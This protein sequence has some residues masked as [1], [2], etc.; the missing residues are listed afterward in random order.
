ML[1]EEDDD[2]NEDEDGGRPKQHTTRGEEKKGNCLGGVPRFF[3]TQSPRGIRGS[4]PIR[5]MERRKKTN[6]APS[7]KI[8]GLGFF[9]GDGR[10]GGT[11]V[12]G[13]G[14]GGGVSGRI[15]K[16]SPLSLSLSPFIDFFFWSCLLLLLLLLPLLL[17]LL[18]LTGRACRLT[19]SQAVFSKSRPTG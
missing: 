8:G 19:H 12:N 5:K 6:G 1:G 15:V 2:G 9:W 4:L 7:R 18:L 11:L 3:D 14:G 16:G 17:L 10:A 13:L